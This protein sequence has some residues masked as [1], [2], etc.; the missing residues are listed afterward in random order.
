MKLSN[1]MDITQ[2]TL[3]SVPSA[4]GPQNPDSGSFGDQYG[5][6]IP[7]VVKTVE[8]G[9]GSV[10][11]FGVG[12]EDGGSN[13]GWIEY[14]K[15]A[16]K[17]LDPVILIKKAF[18]SET[19]FFIQ[20]GE[21][22]IMA[23]KRLGNHL[24]GVASAGWAAIFVALT[25]VGNAPGIGLGLVSVLFMV[26][27]PLTVLGVTLSYVLPWMPAATWIAIIVAWLAQVFETIIA[28]SLWAVMHLHPS[29]DDLTG[30][31]G[32]GYNLLL[33]VILRPV[34][35]VFGMMFA[36]IV[37]NIVGN[38]INNIFADAFV[39]SQQ[40][41]SVWI[42]LIG[43]IAAPIIYCVGQFTLMKKTFGFM[44]IIS[45]QIM[46]WVSGGSHSLASYAGAMASGDDHK[47]AFN[48]IAGV[49]NQG[50]NGMKND[51]GKSLGGG[52]GEIPFSIPQGSNPS[53]SQKKLGEM[54]SSSKE[55]AWAKYESDT[56]RKKNL[57]DVKNWKQLS[58]SFDALG[59]KDSAMG[60]KF[61]ENLKGLATSSNPKVKDMSQ[62][63]MMNTAMDGTLRQ[64]FGK[65]AA[66]ALKNYSGG[67]TSSPEFK[68][69]LGKYESAMKNAVADM[70]PV[71]AKMEIMKVSEAINA[72]FNENKAELKAGSIT[73]ADI[74]DKHL[75][76][77]NDTAS[78]VAES[79]VPAV[80]DPAEAVAPAVVAPEAVPGG[81]VPVA[82]GHAVADSHVAADPGHVVA[83]G[84]GESVGAGEV[85]PGTALA[86]GVEQQAPE[87]ATVHPAESQ[88]S[89]VGQAPAEPIQAPLSQEVS[90]ES[91]KTQEAAPVAPV[92]VL[93][94]AGKVAEAPQSQVMEKQFKDVI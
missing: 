37:L 55:A 42:W 28:S 92:K 50:A 78:P 93:D 77:F 71:Q 58:G 27:T 23:E 84:V 11:G 31:G 75:S 49:A 16:I 4:T 64:E 46:Q 67:N 60:K 32:N 68:E 18:T 29:G 82:G 43:M 47:Q 19:N 69:G 72:D 3:A 85:V 74:F 35:A 73:P 45:D 6:L 63:Q 2:R 81:D 89:V 59:G 54:L 79:E 1:L 7:A 48:A 94:G 88:A 41:S 51:G 12:N 83:E 39:V 56:S 13:K 36:L 5:G 90:G 10:V 70:G 9:G 65:G 33:G 20:D 8:K 80:K 26:V 86:E 17:S 61:E 22:P 66:S 38:F 21:N 34:L 91:V 24:L 76:K 40:D 44:H 30:K 25:T 14:A 53:D 57:D 87:M 52:G 62:S 15:K